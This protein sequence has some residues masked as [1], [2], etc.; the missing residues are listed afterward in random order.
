MRQLF[1]VVDK[2]GDSVVEQQEIARMLTQAYT[3]LQMARMLVQG[4]ITLQMARMFIQ[5]YI[6]YNVCHGIH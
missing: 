3:T 2:N 1:A 6:Y 5:G 4:Y